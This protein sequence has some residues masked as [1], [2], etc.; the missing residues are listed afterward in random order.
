[1]DQL[2]LSTG[3]TYAIFNENGTL[4]GHADRAGESEL[5][6]LRADRSGKARGRG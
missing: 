1:M 2:G 5:C 3:Q 4:E 6:L